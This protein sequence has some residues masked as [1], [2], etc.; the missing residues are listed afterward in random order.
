MTDLLRTDNISTCFAARQGVVA[1]ISRREAAVVRAVDE[2]DIAVGPGEIVGL[3]GE[4]GCGKT[5]LGR[6]ILGLVPASDGA[7]TFDGVD[8]TKLKVGDEVR[9]VIVEA[10]VLNVER[11][12]AGK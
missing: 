8:I 7:V 5:T 10:L 12:T 4:S 1:R 6:T 3:V 11:L 2:V 9:A